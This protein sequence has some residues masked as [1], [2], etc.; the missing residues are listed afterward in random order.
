MRLLAN[1]FDR[2][3]FADWFVRRDARRAERFL[4][5]FD[6]HWRLAMPHGEVYTAQ[7]RQGTA[8]WIPPGR[9]KA[10]LWDELLYLPDMLWM[11]GIRALL[12]KADAVHLAEQHHPTG[13]HYYSLALG[14]LPEFRRQGIGSALMQPILSRCDASKLPAYLETT[15]EPNVLFYEHHGFQ[16]REIFQLPRDGPKAWLMWREPVQKSG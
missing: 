3:P 12:A 7:E 4:R 16:V 15:S 8:L 13:P 6:V 9:W 2:E 10:N 5:F 1:A 14:T 11:T